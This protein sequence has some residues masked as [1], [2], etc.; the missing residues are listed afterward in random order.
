MRKGSACFGLALTFLGLMVSSWRWRWHLVRTLMQVQRLN[1]RAISRPDELQGRDLNIAP[2]CI[3]LALQSTIPITVSYGPSGSGSP[4]RRQQRWGPSP[5]LPHQ[6]E[7]VQLNPPT[8]IRLD[9][10]DGDSVPSHMSP[11]SCRNRLSA[12]A[13]SYQ[14]DYVVN[15]PP[16]S[17]HLRGLCLPVIYL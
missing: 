4:L 13:I 10:C 5:S 3:R 15:T 8:L 1:L 6:P 12:E 2:W 11:S 7:S 16:L 14:F 17:Q 9:D